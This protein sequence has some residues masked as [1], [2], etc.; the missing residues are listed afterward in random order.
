MTR[1]GR[2]PATAHSSIASPST[3]RAC[4]AQRSARRPPSKVVV[5][6]CQGHPAAS[7]TRPRHERC[8]IEVSRGVA[9]QRRCP[10][11]TFHKAPPRR[12]S[13]DHRSACRWPCWP[14]GR[15]GNRF[16]RPPDARWPPSRTSMGHAS[17]STSPRKGHEPCTTRSGTI[18][19]W[20]A[21]RM[22]LRFCTLIGTWCMRSRRR[23]PLRD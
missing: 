19:W 11:L 6:L 13:A 12:P 1:M 9:V 14:A 20:M 15:G 22:A 16:G 5:F 18:T 3:G 2:R 23:R 7:A 8:G 4:G 17:P 21:P 10:G